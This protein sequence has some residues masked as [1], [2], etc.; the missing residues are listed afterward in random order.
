MPRR[1][2][3]GD[4]V[5]AMSCRIAGGDFDSAGGA[6]RLLKEQLVK[7]GVGAAVIRRVMIASYEAEMN[8]VIHARTGTLWARLSDGALDLEVADEGPGIPDVEAALREGWSTA[9]D[10]AR[11]MGFGA[12]MGLPN[13][14][15]NSDL[16]EIETRV[17]R[18]T[19]IRS[20]IILSSIEPRAEGAPSAARSA[21]SEAPSTAPDRCRHCHRCLIA[22]PTA[23]LRVH[24]KGPEIIQPLCI[25]CTACISECAAG[26]YGIDAAGPALDFRIPGNALL[27]L[28]RGFLSGFGLEAAPGQVLAGLRSLGFTEVRY[29]DEWEHAVRAAAVQFAARG[30][31]PLPVIPPVC[32][33]VVALVESRFPSLI[34]Q[35]G[36][37]LSPVEAAAEE[38]PLRPVVLV[39]S[40]PM[41]NALAV[42]ASLTERVTAVSPARLSAAVRTCLGGRAAPSTAVPGGTA[43]PGG[44]AEPQPGV[45]TVSG[46]RH[47]LRVLEAA[48]AGM[49]EGIKVLDLSL[50][51]SG[52]SGSPL[53]TSDPYLSERRWQQAGDAAMGAAAGAMAVPRRHPC[54]QRHG[55]RLDPDMAEAMRKLAAIDEEERALPGRNCGACGAPTC[56]AFAEDIIMGRAHTACCPHK[57]KTP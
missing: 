50:C 15:R 12:G 40:C 41:Q 3:A 18:G 37:W 45:L 16:F 36:S 46:V 10:K 1:G 21:L 29:L 11:E 57:E 52:C 17:G 25:G 34:P 2:A 13:I 9:S 32:P 4:S 27:V 24:D 56:A 19:R 53:L 44:S 31:G 49:L 39:P 28:P 38:F 42:A 14:R 8:V 47:V 7:I 20:R 33:A 55:M 43:A 35:L 51:D 48:E 22:C 54:Q 6:T 23:A 26:V 30:K 5:I